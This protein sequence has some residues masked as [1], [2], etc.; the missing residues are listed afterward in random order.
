[1]KKRKPKQEIDTARL[2]R[3]SERIWPYTDY[4]PLFMTDQLRHRWVKSVIALGDR[5]VLANKQTK[6]EEPLP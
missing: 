6:L 3:M 5:W 1:M 4:V 2:S